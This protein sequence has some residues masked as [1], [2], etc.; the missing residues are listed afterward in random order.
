MKVL[1][2]EKLIC[3]VI[4]LLGDQVFGVTK[5]DV[6]VGRILVLRISNKKHL[7]LVY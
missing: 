1:G 4:L 2:V 3:W 6:V 7:L 5:F